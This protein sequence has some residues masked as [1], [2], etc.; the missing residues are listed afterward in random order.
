MCNPGLALLA[1]GGLGAAGNIAQGIQQKRLSQ[2]NAQVARQNA[3]TERQLS[4]VEEMRFRRRSE[5]R[6]ASQR[7]ADVGS[8]F[9]PTFGT[10]ANL[11]QESAANA[12]L[13]AL[14]IRFGRNQ[15]ANAFESQA[16]LDEAEGRNA[17]TR[18]LIGAGAQILQGGVD[19]RLAA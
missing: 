15:R 14:L 7:A 2:Y 19:A 4:L 16:N 17:L 9:D 13:D 6:L 18:G 3:N 8:G 1:A 5:Q 11:A 10:P 12:E